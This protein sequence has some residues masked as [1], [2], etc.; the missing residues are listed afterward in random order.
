M[1]LHDEVKE[2]QDKANLL[3][4]AVLAVLAFSV[5]LAAMWINMSNR[6]DDLQRE[7]NMPIERR[8]ELSPFCV[9]APD[10]RSVLASRKTADLRKP[11]PLN[12]SCL[13]KFDLP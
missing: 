11:N 10:E 13:I 4:L 7:V 5:A 6:I 9:F 8:V 12:G 1:P 3:V 2:L